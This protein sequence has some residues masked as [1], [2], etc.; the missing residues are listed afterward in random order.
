AVTARVGEATAGDRVPAGVE[1]T[2]EGASG[3][4]PLGPPPRPPRRAGPT[5]L[6]TEHALAD[7]R[8]LPAV[9]PGVEPGRIPLEPP[10]ADGH[11]QLRRR[12][13][14]PLAPGGPPI[15]PNRRPKAG[16]RPRVST[17]QRLVPVTERSPGFAKFN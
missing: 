15:R 16:P 8:V 4:S 6:G 1:A 10:V 7:G 12:E 17:T 9:R 11:G 2:P 14:E 5:V 13:P 3:R